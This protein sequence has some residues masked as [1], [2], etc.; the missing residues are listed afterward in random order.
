MHIL[1][2]LYWK[3]NLRTPTYIWREG[4]VIKNRERISKRANFDASFG[5]WMKW[6]QECQERVTQTCQREIGTGWILERENGD[7]P[8]WISSAEKKAG[9]GRNCE[10]S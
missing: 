2:S 9:E 10:S 1:K 5:V 3:N 4:G 7:A 6:E 8:I